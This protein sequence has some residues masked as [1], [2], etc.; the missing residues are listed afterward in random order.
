[1]S[2]GADALRTSVA[3]AEGCITR[4]HVHVDPLRMDGVSLSGCEPECVIVGACSD[5]IPAS[6]TDRLLRLCALRNCTA[7]FCEPRAV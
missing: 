6:G 5:L 7:Q 3:E 1:M 4:G 2:T